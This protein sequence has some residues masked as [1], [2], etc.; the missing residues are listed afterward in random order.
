MFKFYQLKLQTLTKLYIGFF[1]FILCLIYLSNIFLPIHAQNSTQ[2]SQTQSI[3]EISQNIGDL[4]YQNL[5]LSES[6]G[7]KLRKN[8]TE[9]GKTY[10][11]SGGGSF[12][13]YDPVVDIKTCTKKEVYS[14]FWNIT[15]R[16][17]TFK[18]LKTPNL[19][20]NAQANNFYKLTR[21]TKP[22]AVSGYAGRIVDNVEYTN[23]AYKNDSANLA[24]VN[25]LF[26]ART[27]FKDKT[28]SNL[29]KENISFQVEYKDS[30]CNIVQTNFF[31][32]VMKDKKEDTKANNV[33]SIILLLIFLFIAGITLLV[34]RFLWKL[35]SKVK[36]NS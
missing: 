5:N 29:D 20:L 32:I 28:N 8:E 12:P 27:Y 3:S 25:V 22:N 35:L 36:E 4:E 34:G 6:D 11:G 30:K 13:K 21:N 19:A 18:N 23:T 31:E 24:Y 1:L 33:I 7:V 14:F 16:P 17:G 10:F 2:N 15:N 9:M 26:S